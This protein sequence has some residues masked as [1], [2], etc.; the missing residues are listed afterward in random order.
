M[1]VVCNVAQYN[2]L[3]VV[4]ADMELYQVRRSLRG[5]LEVLPFDL[6]A[7]EFE[8]NT[9]G[10]DDFKRF[11]VFSH[12]A[13]FLGNETREIIVDLAL[14]NRSTNFGDIDGDDFAILGV[15][16]RAEVKGE[17]VLIVRK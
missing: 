16:D 2:T 4:E 14:G 12:G 17:R 7:T 15:D 3:T 13:V 9:L 11:E 10:L 6:A 5:Y 1:I 8:T